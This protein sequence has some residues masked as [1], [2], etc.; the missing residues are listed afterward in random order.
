MVLY[1]VM[2]KKVKMFLY[3]NRQL[4]EIIL[5]K[6]FV[7]LVMVKLLNLILLKGKKF[8]F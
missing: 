6:L 7:V 3:I 4:N 1:H 2:I 5:G 8:V